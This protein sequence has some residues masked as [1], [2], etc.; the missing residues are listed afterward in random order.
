MRSFRDSIEANLARLQ[1]FFNIYSYYEDD[2][3]YIATSQEN[4]LENEFG[5][6]LWIWFQLQIL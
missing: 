4:Q 6:S 2:D 3:D 1:L 5:S